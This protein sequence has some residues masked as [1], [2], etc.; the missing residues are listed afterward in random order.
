VSPPPECNP[1]AVV[2]RTPQPPANGEAGDVWVNPKDGMEMVYVSAGEFT[3]GTSDAQIDAWLKEHPGDKR[4]SFANEQPQCR[5]N[6]PG[7]WI[8]RTEVTNGQYLR[9]VQASGQRA[10]EHW[11]D[12]KIP[13]GLESLPVVFVDWQDVRAY[14]E[15]AGGHL[16]T[17]LQWEK[18]ARATDGRIFPWGNQWDNQRCRNF[19]AIT[20]NRYS[21]P[22][23]LLSEMQ[24][25]HGSHDP[26][27]D[28]PAAVG[29]YP[30]AASAYGC[31]D[32]A[33]NVWE[34]CADW[35]D[36]EAYKRYARASGSESLRLGEAD[37]TPPA[38]G[39][40]RVLRGGSWGYVDP[41]N[42]RCADRFGSDPGV[43][44]DND[45][46]RCARDASP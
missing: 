27:R 38:K 14:C 34:W 45:G 42:F 1:N 19:E 44:S 6:L 29:S 35:Y 20:G 22:R 8:G 12:G 28:G 3:L 37:L 43:R 5:V 4:E 7:Y 13:S 24:D 31:A 46:F 9:F 41:G 10:P 2:W 18:A 36:G 39:E 33:G 21:D 25:W 16:P 11:K 23:K 15:W 26:V 30:A 40:Y 17:E 32:M